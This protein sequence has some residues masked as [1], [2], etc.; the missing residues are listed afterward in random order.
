MLRLLF[1]LSRIFCELTLCFSHEG[2]TIMDF[3]SAITLIQD[4]LN[5]WLETFISNL[6]NLIIAALVII[7]FHVVGLYVKRITQK[8]LGKVSRNVALDN[9]FST[10]AR[11][12]VVLIGLLIAINILKLDK[13]LLSLLAGVGVIGLAL[14]FAFQDVA[15][16]FV[17]GIA[18]VFRRDHPFKVGDLIETNGLLGVVQ[19]IN[20]RD[21]MIYTP[22]GQVIFLPNKLIFENSVT[23]YSILQK[24]R[25]DLEVGVSYGDNLEKVKEVTI[26]ALQGLPHMLSD[27]EIQ[28]FF[29]EFG[30]SSI[31]LTAVI[32]VEYKTHA[33]YVSTISDAVM[34][35]KAAYDKNNITIPFPIRTLD[36]GIKGGQNL[37]EMLNHHDLA[38]AGKN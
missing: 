14:A 29:S 24:R 28:I 27:T 38:T 21:T 37:S 20:L 7:G 36:F 19:E 25:I 18:L 31:N 26:A 10:I 13:A 32:W 35:I 12:C 34:R 2:A 30:S 4:K 9:F 22:H 8:I 1:V 23:N 3:S 17:A 16:N 5:A 11:L 6:P 33:Q 15:S